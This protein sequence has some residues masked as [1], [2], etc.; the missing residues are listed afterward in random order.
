MTTGC[1]VLG[2]SKSKRTWSNR[3]ILNFFRPKTSTARVRKC[4]GRTH[5]NHYFSTPTYTPNIH[6]FSNSHNLKHTRL[7]RYKRDDLGSLTYPPLY[8][9]GNQNRQMSPR[10]TISKLKR[11]KPRERK[12]FVRTKQRRPGLVEVCGRGD[13]AKSEFLL[14]SH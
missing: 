9:L 13:S 5:R 12:H 7:Q 14:C 8:R 6:T 11:K 2:Y 4:D 3:L 1:S 10:P